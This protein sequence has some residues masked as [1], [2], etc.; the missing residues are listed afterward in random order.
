MATIFLDMDGVVADFDAY[1]EPIVGYKSPGGHRY[2]DEDWQ[3]IS[4]NP[5]LYSIL[6]KC[7]DADRLVREV[8]ELAKQHKMSVGFLSAI[9]KENN[10]HWVFWD[11]MQWVQKNYP[12]VPLFLGPYS[13]D[14]QNHYTPGD[15][16]I[17]DR[18]SNVEEW[19][20]VGG[21]AILHE[22]DVIATLFELRSLVNSSTG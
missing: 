18:I 1:A 22:G 21:K 16:L 10:L 12:G 6:P 11:K 14:K 4:V 5:R 17:D 19:R 2:N 9:P 7:H 8:Q 15:I 20:A 13:R 3:K